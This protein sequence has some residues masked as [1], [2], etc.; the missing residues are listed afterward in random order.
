M[1]QL[2]NFRVLRKKEE[3][4]AIS[5]GIYEVYYD[6]HGNPQYCSNSS[7]EPKEENVRDLKTQI[8]QMLKAFDKPILKHEDF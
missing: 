5:Y 1:S 8:I 4:G 7:M 2:W 3:N 6:K